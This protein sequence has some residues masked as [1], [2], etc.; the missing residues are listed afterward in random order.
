M[1]VCSLKGVAAFALG[2]LISL[3][4][5]T[6]GYGTPRRP[7]PATAGSL[8]DLAL[9]LAI[10]AILVACLG[11]SLYYALLTVYG[12][13]RDMVETVAVVRQVLKDRA[14]LRRAGVLSRGDAPVTI[15]AA[16]LLPPAIRADGIATARDVLASQTDASSPRR[17]VRAVVARLIW[18]LI[19][20][21]V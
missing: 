17:V 10:L 18:G 2:S 14:A 20:D 12:T 6:L 13:A 21:G 9:S 11:A 15:A 16:L 7:S 1:P 5:T 4:L 8:G 3:G 19:R